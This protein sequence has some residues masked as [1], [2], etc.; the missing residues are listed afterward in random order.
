MTVALSAFLDAYD[1]DVWLWLPALEPEAAADAAL[2]QD[3][4]RE[5]ETVFA[6]C[7]R[8]DRV[9]METGGPG[10]MAADV[11]FT[12]YLRELAAALH[13]HHPQAQLWASPAR[14]SQENLARFYKY[15]QEQQPDWIAGVVWG[16]GCAD[17]LR[18]TREM[19][20]EKY[21]IRLYPDITH[22]L[23]CQSPFPYLDEPWAQAYARQPIEPRPTQYA[24]IWHNVSP[25]SA[26][27]VCYSEGTGDDVNKVIWDALLWDPKAEV[28]DVLRDFGRCF[29][30]PE[31]ADEV[32]D[33]E[34]MLE[35][36]W[37]GPAATNP[38]V[39]Q[40]FAHWQAIEKR[41]TPKQ[42]ANW[43]LQ[44]GLVRAYGDMFVQTRL[45]R[46]LKLLDR[47]YAELAKAPTVGPQAAMDAA[48][49]ALAQA[50]PLTAAPAL[51]QRLHELGGELFK[52]IGMQLSMKEYG[53]N[54]IQRGAQ[55]DNNDQ[56]VT[57]C[58]WLRAQLAE[59]RKLPTREE[60]LAAIAQWV[61]W[62]NPGPGGFYDDLGNHANLMDPHLVREVTW[63]QDPDLV[64]AIEDT[65][66][67]PIPGA[68]LY[69][70]MSWLNQAQSVVRPL[71]LRYTGLDPNA[72]YILKATYAGRSAGTYQLFV[73]GE[74]LGDPVQSDPQ[75]PAWREFEVPRSATAG[76][77]LDVT[78][79]NVRGGGAQIAEAW[80]MKAK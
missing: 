65:H 63:E 52:S 4:L 12:T 55:L 26:G 57:D 32:A 68:P 72:T 15:L 62:T 37:V 48:D 19:I 2:R 20:P 53:S 58:N 41:A 18:H 74:R 34:L 47:A 1:M 8:I 31:F 49:N 22:T 27:S 33:G 24:H 51:R 29:F 70:R 25:Y 44:Q 75:K 71:H 3:S 6:G 38:Q 73:N 17:T 7:R 54:D 77:T 64:L 39:A 14:I 42:L 56:P 5:L 80:L 21:P 11:F 35:K 50:D 78:W 9:F 23:R 59:I 28:R 61:S 30:G 16:P 46:D 76:G 69:R 67:G 13:R 66:A 45:R 40:T 79:S 36:N 10:G 43:R 60:Q